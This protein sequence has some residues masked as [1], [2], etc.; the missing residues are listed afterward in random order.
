MGRQDENIAYL[1]AMPAIIL[2]L[3]FKL[4]PLFGAFKLPF[5]DYKF[6]MG[7]GGSPYIGLKNFSDLFS[8]YYFRR[9]VSNTLIL[10]FGFV[11]ISGII[12][13]ILGWALSHIEKRWFR[14]Y[15]HTIYHTFLF[16]RRCLAM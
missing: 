5:V 14:K 9:L 16:L 11:F 12:A 6:T 10:K 7:I 4:I 8:T 2:A 3:I 13:F 1:I 15:Y